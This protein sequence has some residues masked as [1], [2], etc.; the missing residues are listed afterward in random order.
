MKSG[1]TKCIS[2][3]KKISYLQQVQF[4][5]LPKEVMRQAVKYVSTMKQSQKQ[6]EFLVMFNYTMNP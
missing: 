4:N 2:S 5:Y 3:W 1:F 6:S